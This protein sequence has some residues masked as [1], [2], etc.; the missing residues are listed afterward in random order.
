MHIGYQ[1]KSETPPSVP[2][3]KSI[4]NPV[5]RLVH[6]AALQTVELRA[7]KVAATTYTACRLRQSIFF[8]V[9]C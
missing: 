3:R 4:V 8:V 5:D 9:F 2:V 7:S 6:E 1:G